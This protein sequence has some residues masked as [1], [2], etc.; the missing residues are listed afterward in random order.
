M[1]RLFYG[2]FCGATKANA[3]MF[4]LYL[5]LMKKDSWFLSLSLLRSFPNDQS[6]QPIFAA[7]V[8]VIVI[9]HIW[10]HTTTR[11]SQNEMTRFTFEWL[12]FCCTTRHMTIALVW[13]RMNF[14][15]NDWTENWHNTNW[16]SV[17][18]TFETREREHVTTKMMETLNWFLKPNYGKSLCSG[19]HNFILVNLF[20]T[21]HYV[22][23][24][25]HNSLY[26]YFYSHT[27]NWPSIFVL[28]EASTKNGVCIGF[29]C[30]R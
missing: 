6:V 29:V 5:W 16:M 13:I 27:P 9:T 30:E 17:V 22:K 14:D 26:F 21:L 18:V 28:A 8:V 23:L 15:L 2:P 12:F 1:L 20:S 3:K 11:E 25:R 24:H 7:V 4:L 19:W 10:L